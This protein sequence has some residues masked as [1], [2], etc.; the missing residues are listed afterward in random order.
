[1]N[2]ELTTAWR[3]AQL[4]EVA[5]VD[6]TGAPQA[7]VVVP[8]LDDRLPALALPYARLATA[9]SIAAAGRVTWTLAVPAVAG[10]AV[11]VAAAA[12]VEVIEDPAGERFIAT[13]LLD[14]V[15]A[16]HP[17]ARR[18][19]DSVLL[20][21]EHG[22]YVPRLIIRTTELGPSFELGVGEAL[23]VSTAADGG[24]WVAAAHQ[25]SVA[26]GTARLPIDDGPAF[27]LQHGADIPDLETPW[28]RRWRGTVEAGRFRAIERDEVPLARRPPGLRDRLRTE[29][30][31]HR[32][33]RDGLREAG[34]R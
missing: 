4:G 32:A 9:R 1:M 11:P 33:C 23:G 27:V 19:L 25:V 12:H 24:P 5:W 28:H 2:G 7:E 6:A 20:R 8:L 16:K 18:R 21:R 15:L 22:W 26:D 31:L 30:T 29:R 10:G 17:P 34:H 14:Q 13:S 3:T